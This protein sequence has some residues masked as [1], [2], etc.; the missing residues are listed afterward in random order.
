MPWWKRRGT[1]VFLG[2]SSAVGTAATGLGAAILSGLSFPGEAFFKTYGT[3][4]GLVLAL[5]SSI[6]L[7]IAAHKDK[8]LEERVA[9]LEGEVQGAA[10]LLKEEKSQ[11]KSDGYQAAASRM[12]SQLEKHHKHLPN[13]NPEVGELLRAEAVE[14]AREFL[15]AIG[16]KN[17]RVSFYTPS[18][19]EEDPESDQNPENGYTALSLGHASCSPGRHKPKEVHLYEERTKHMFEAM[20]SAAPSSPPMRENVAGWKAARQL[21]VKSNGFEP[22]GLLTADSTESSP[23]PAQADDILILAV[24]LILLINRTTK[25]KLSG[26]YSSGG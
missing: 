4:G 10:R 20:S 21:G 26:A 7:A 12:K 9:E 14:L 8:G 25:Q 2:I 16:V 19:S 6:W 18:A 3:F 1:R 24:E 23:F 11:A 13:W 15:E 17:V 22:Q 5:V